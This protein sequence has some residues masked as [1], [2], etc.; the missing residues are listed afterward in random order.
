MTG[1]WQIPGSLGTQA[2]LPCS[3]L[4]AESP[5]LWKASDF[6]L[7]AFY[8][9]DEAYPPHGEPSPLLKVN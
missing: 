6:A 1:G 4:E 9:F 7:K 8:P 5:F 3:S 2:E